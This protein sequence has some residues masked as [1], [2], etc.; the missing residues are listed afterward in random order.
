MN[1]FSLRFSFLGVLLVLGLGVVTWPQSVH[2]TGGAPLFV[3]FP[4]PE[5]VDICGEPLPLERQGVW[6]MLDREFTI[7]VWDRA[8][9]FMWL[10]RAGRFF[11]LVEAELAKAKMPDDLKYLAVAESAMLNHVRSSAGA[12]GPWQFM[13][14]TAREKGLRKDRSMDERRSLERSTAA[15]LAYLASLREQFGSWTLAM[16]AYNCGENRMRR[17]IKEQKTSDYYSLD[18]PRETE[19]YIFRIAAIKIIMENPEHYGY[20]LP[21]ARVYTP[22]AVDRVP[23]NLAGDF[24]IGDV[25]EKLGTSFKGLKE[26]NP[27]ILG[28]YLPVGRY[29]LK[30]PEGTGEKLPGILKD[31]TGKRARRTHKAPYYVVK[32]GDTLGGISRKTGVS[33]GR[34]KKLN[35]VR[36]SHIMAG[37]KLRL[38]STS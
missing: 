33:V 15:A 18:L 22:L 2:A 38:K 16:A 7:S 32:P 4:M 10:K 20:R 35:K 3:E 19:R 1:A 30:V 14:A 26:L 25:A 37:Q 27:Q 12:L 23:V 8:Q 5:S 24:H 31:L 13:K 28:S 17:T 34:L 36:G 21:K 9:T 6:E 11:P 29:D